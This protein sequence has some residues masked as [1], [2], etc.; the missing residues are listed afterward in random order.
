[1][2]IVNPREAWGSVQVL[3]IF[4]HNQRGQQGSYPAKASIPILRAVLFLLPDLQELATDSGDQC[5]GQ[6]NMRRHRRI[7]MHVESDPEV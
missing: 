4:L 7:S 3:S 2:I 5:N 1:M 6:G